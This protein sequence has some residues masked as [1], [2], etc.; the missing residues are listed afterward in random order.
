MELHL[1]VRLV[2]DAE[3]C[4]LIVAIAVSTLKWL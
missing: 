2:V 4:A 1:N 3:L